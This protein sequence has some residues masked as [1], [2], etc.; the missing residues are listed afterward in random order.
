[1]RYAGLFSA[2]YH[3]AASL[4]AAFSLRTGRDGARGLLAVCLLALAW[5]SVGPAAAAACTARV[6]NLTF[7]DVDTLASAPSDGTADID[8]DCT[9]VTTGAAAV[10]VCASIGAGSGGSDAGE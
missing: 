9:D 6:T 8:I 7:A 3:R 2:L 5:L 10:T 4:V 1:M